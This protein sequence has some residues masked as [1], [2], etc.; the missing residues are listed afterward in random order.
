M[1]NYNVANGASALYNNTTGGFNIGIGSKANYYNQTGSSNTIIGYQAGQRTSLQNISGNIFLGYRAGYY[2]QT[3]N[4]LYIENSNS[5]SP[6]IWGDFT[7][8]SERVVINGM[9][10]V[11]MLVMNFMSTEMP[12]D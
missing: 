3:D 12:A 11:E 8:G 4:K 5:P 9:E 6:L 2:E 1:G 7:N 10:Q